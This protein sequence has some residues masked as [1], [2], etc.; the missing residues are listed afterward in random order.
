MGLLPSAWARILGLHPTHCWAG[1]GTSKGFRFSGSTDCKPFTPPR[2]TKSAG[3]NGDHSL[4]GECW[5]H[6]L[7]LPPPYGCPA[8]SDGAHVV[9][10]KGPETKKGQG[11]R[12]GIF[13]LLCWG[14]W[15]GRACTAPP[16]RPTAGLRIH[17]CSHVPLSL[18]L[19]IHQPLRV[20]PQ[21][22]GSAPILRPRSGCP[23]PATETPARP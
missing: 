11:K 17:S 18:S 13:G 14:W 6:R 7:L 2:R 12:E 3:G 1:A 20:R 21:L 19:T 4:H 8:P 5:L 23:A 10:A 22:R 16:P 9:P 15:F